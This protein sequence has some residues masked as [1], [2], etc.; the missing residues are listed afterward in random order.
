MTE[1]LKKLFGGLEISWK[2]LII[3]AVISGVYTGI[4]AMLPPV[5]DTSFHDIAMSFEWWVLFGILIIINSRSAKEA[6]LKCFVF[7]L[8]SQPLVYL[9]QAPFHPDGLRL[10]RYYPGWFVWTLCTLPMGCIGYYLKKQQWWGLLILTPV[11]V[12]VG[13][14]YE[15]FLSSTLSFFPR[16]L[17]SALFCAA[18][19]LLYPLCIF[20]EKKLKRAGL[21][22]GLLLLVVMTVV[23]TGNQKTHYETYILSSGSHGITLDES[24]SVSLADESCGDVEIV[25]DEAI[26]TH[27]VKAT[28][29]KDGETQLIV[30]GAD[31]TETLF[32]LVV[33]NSSFRLTPQG[34]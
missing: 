32:T 27:L 9:V 16:H 12:F 6:A 5:R 7:F 20:T 23:A 19:M 11:L 8:I 30:T 28:F 21:L 29:S 14:H 2:G 17:L 10:F 4:M 1:K 18:T 34:S 13:F 15:S 3:F 33:E 22:I 31:G 25:Y 26:G 24:C